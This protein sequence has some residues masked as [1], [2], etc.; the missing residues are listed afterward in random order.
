[1]TSEAAISLI[2]VKKLAN[3]IF[4][5]LIVQGIDTVA[6]KGD[7]FWQIYFAEA[8]DMSKTP[9][10]TVGSITDCMADVRQET[11]SDEMIGW[12]A[13]HHLSGILTFL[14]DAANDGFK[15]SR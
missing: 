15:I 8:F 13:L 2:E 6:V 5:R 12:H 11:S 4:D 10:A 3:E 14:A 1:M 7:E 9:E